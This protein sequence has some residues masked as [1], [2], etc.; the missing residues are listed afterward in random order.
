MEDDMV[1]YGQKCEI[2]TYRHSK[3]KNGESSV[4]V[5]SDPL[6]KGA[7]SPSV[8]NTADASYALVV[9]RFMDQKSDLAKTTLQVNS[10]YILK[11]FRDV[12]GSDPTVVSDF[13]RPF[14]MASPFPVLLHN[15]DDLDSQWRT[16]E[17]AEE[18]MHLNLLFEFMSNDLGPARDELR[19]M[20]KQNR[21]TYHRA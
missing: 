3:K 5:I 13:T 9:K 16:T 20:V 15:W 18:R 2:K 6:G 21:I 4:E 19:G 12:I 14:K 17:D 7:T 10:P 11:S 1:S 8:P